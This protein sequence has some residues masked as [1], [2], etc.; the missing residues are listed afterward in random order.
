MA[1]RHII[2]L[3]RHAQQTQPVLSL[4]HNRALLHSSIASHNGSTFPSFALP[5]SPRPLTL[6]LQERSRRFHCRP[7]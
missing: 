4:R 5:L 3:K 6:C 1:K 2:D 7:R